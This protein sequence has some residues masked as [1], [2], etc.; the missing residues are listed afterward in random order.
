MNELWQFALAS[1]LSEHNGLTLVG[2]FCIRE[3]LNK[4][5]APEEKDEELKE[6]LKDEIPLEHPKVGWL[7]C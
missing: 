4:P 7:S 3:H 1:S 6:P 5:N 2:C